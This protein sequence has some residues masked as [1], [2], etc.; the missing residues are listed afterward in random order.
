MH[1]K[2]DLYFDYQITN[3]LLVNYTFILTGMT[4]RLI[5]NKDDAEKL[6]KLLQKY[7]VH[8][9]EIQVSNDYKFSIFWISEKRREMLHKNEDFQKSIDKDFHLKNYKIRQENIYHVNLYKILNVFQ[10]ISDFDDLKFELDLFGRPTNAEK[11][12]NPSDCFNSDALFKINKKQVY[13]IG[14]IEVELVL[15]YDELSHNRTSTKQNDKAKKDQ[16]IHFCDECLDYQQNKNEDADE[17]NYCEYFKNS[18]II[19]IFKYSCTILD[20]SAILCKILYFEHYSGTNLKK[21]TEILNNILNY[22]QNDRVNME[23]IFEN[24]QP[25]DPNIGKKFKTYHDFKKCLQDEYNIDINDTFCKYENFA[26]F[27]VNCDLNMSDRLHDYK[28]IYRCTETKLREASQEIIKLLKK[29][30]EKKESL[31][32]YIKYIIE[33]YTWKLK[34]SSIIMEVINNMPDNDASILQYVLDKIR[35][36]NV[37]FIFDYMFKTTDNYTIAKQIEKCPNIVKKI[38]A[39]NEK[40]INSDTESDNVSNYSSDTESE[41]EKPIKKKKITLC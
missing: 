16:Y 12:F 13:S 27:I 38:L 5:K 35:K 15:E 26:K 7:G 32:N 22:I 2:I 36:L 20:N 6:E 34:D 23:E 21:D 1:R 29:N 18:V 9:I 39:N 10:S 4:N 40:K 28:N 17:N 33:N 11:I 3:M 37:N 30:I 14:N 31:P 24:F 19:T 41:D 8:E 25:R